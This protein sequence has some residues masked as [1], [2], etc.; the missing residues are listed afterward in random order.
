MS[1]GCRIGRRFP[2]DLQ[3]RPRRYDPV[4][5]A[6][7]ARLAKGP[8]PAGIAALLR[9]ADEGDPRRFAQLCHEIDDAHILSVLGTRKRAVANLEWHVEPASDDLVDVRI[10]QEAERALRAI[11]RLHGHLVDLLDAIFKGY[12]AAEIEWAA[13]ARG[14]VQ[15]VLP[16]R[17][18]SRPQHWLRP[19]LDDLDRWRVLSEQDPVEGEALQP[20]GW[21]LHTSRAKAG[22]AHQAGLGRAL[23]WWWLF[24]QYIAKDWVSFAEKFGSP[25]RVGKFAPTSTKAD[26]D[27]LFEAVVQLGVDAA[28]VIPGDMSVEF[29]QAEATGADVFERFMVYA[30]RQIAKVVLG[31]TLTTEESSRGT[32]ALGTVHNDVREDLR[33]SDAL[34]LEDTLTR[35]VLR[36]FVEYN[37][38]HRFEVPRFTLHT[39]PPADLKVEAETQQL[40]AEV[41]AAA[42]AMGVPVSLR[43]VRDELG[44]EAADAGEP[45][46]PPLGAPAEGS[47]GGGSAPRSALD[48]SRGVVAARRGQEAPSGPL[49]GRD[50]L[51]DGGHHAHGPGGECLQLAAADRK[52]LPAVWLAVADTTAPERR[53]MRLAWAEVVAV[54]VE[55]LVAGD[56]VAAILGR[57]ELRAYQVALAN[58]SLTAELI[59]RLQALEADQLGAHP[60]LATGDLADWARA[61]GTDVDELEE[62]RA[63]NLAQAL[64]AARYAALQAADDLDAVQ[65]LA[66][67]AR[68]SAELHAQLRREGDTLE[69]SPHRTTAVFDQAGVVAWQRGRALQQDRE[70][71]RRPYRRYNSALRETTRRT[72]RAMHARVWRADH[73]VW[74]AWRPPNGWGCLCWVTAHTAAEVEAAGWEISEDLPTNPF[75][76][77]PLTPD[78]GWADNHLLQ[79]HEYD[80]TGFPKAWLDRLGVDAPTTTEGA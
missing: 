12:A 11:P 37:F 46:L 1:L 6:H 31:Q 35:D 43:Q 66:D 59:G 74:Q 69:R 58:G 60:G 17:L 38:G 79:A 70:A 75:D 32:Q 29:V 20:G 53:R 33:D 22:W 73:P 16:R 7:G 34:E 40:R 4:R 50:G 18:H 2:V 39:D 80:W 21:I 42:R 62:R 27:A 63:A 8:T 49:A 76:N 30:D 5:V 48:P 51:Q 36:P 23:I 52:D 64:D 28:A 77:S 72:H 65:S 61:L 24:K 57:L 9:E 55:G 14:D 45:V 15:M 19:D 54:L 10:A 68:S 71:A 41:F 78:A 67:P 44:L 3:A 13:V 47:S 26:I 56:D 25:L